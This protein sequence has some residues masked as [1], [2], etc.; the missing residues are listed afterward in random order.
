M[1]D[2]FKELVNG[3]EEDVNKDF[4]TFEYEV[5][6]YIEPHIKGDLP[7]QDTSIT[8]R[9]FSDKSKTQP[10]PIT[11]KWYRVVDTRNYEIK[12]NPEQDTYHIN[13]Y[14]VGSYLKVSVKA[15][16]YKEWTVIKIGPILLN[17]RLLPEL[18]HSL[19][20][21]DGLYNVKIVKIGD[22][23]IQDDSGHQNFLKFTKNFICMKFGFQ[24]EK[25]Y[26]DFKIQI[27][28]PF[29]YKVICQNNDYRAVS[30]FFKRGTEQPLEEN[31]LNSNPKKKRDYEQIRA[32]WL[33]ANYTKKPADQI[34][35]EQDDESVSQVEHMLIKADHNGGMISQIMHESPKEFNN[36]E[37]YSNDDIEVRVSF[38]SRLY[39]DAF[40]MALRVIT[41][42]RSLALAPLIDNC[43]SVFTKQW[44]MS[45]N[46]EYSVYN[47]LVGQMHHFSGAIRRVLQQNKQ[48]DNQNG[49][50]N[51]C[52]E[53]LEEDLQL[54]FSEFKSIIKS[55]NLGIQKG[56]T[57][58]SLAKVQQ[59]IIETSMH[60]AE[61]KHGAQK[62]NNEKK[63]FQS[64]RQAD[65][66]KAIN[67]DKEI[68]ETNKLNAL[69]LKDINNLK[70]KKDTTQLAAR[71]SSKKQQ[72]NNTMVL[73]DFKNDLKSDQILNRSVLESDKL[74]DYLMGMEEQLIENKQ[75]GQELVKL[76][77]HLHFEVNFKFFL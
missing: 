11:C 36:D 37:E 18:E 66:L 5:P 17:P 73:P 24:F 39:R 55:Q 30:I 28:G 19:L 49:H 33:S 61:M 10:L 22:K 15:K 65:N 2:F 51:S 56:K 34:I 77:E 12:D 60:M 53:A 67:L 29:D 47:Q 70:Q 13:A 14:D 9:G 40:V 64:T 32:E 45:I 38:T 44:N 48:L 58:E 20:A 8:L 4:I 50:L 35:F 21:N 75:K 3:G 25:K 62:F 26:K 76:A 68:K 54:A 6:F 52:V 74:Q 42:M 72:A 41:T 23:F 31:I 63:K 1:F 59:S 71:G 7:Y 16:G 69:L 46:Q 57:M 43:E 27:D